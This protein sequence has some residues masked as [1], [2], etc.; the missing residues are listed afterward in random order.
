MSDE[1]KN[2]G[3]E[4]ETPT[5]APASE[6]SAPGGKAVPDVTDPALA[7]KAAPADKVQPA[8]PEF[9]GSAAP[10]RPKPKKDAQ[11]TA[12]PDKGDPAQAPAG[13]VVDF[14]AVR[15]E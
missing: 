12:I 10:E 7:E 2:I 6:Q 8:A 4:V 3:P 15:E 11:Q 14:A 5:G 1:K 9:P 13:K